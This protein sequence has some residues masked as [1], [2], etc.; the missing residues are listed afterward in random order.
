MENEICVKM[1][2][3]VRYVQYEAEEHQ[4]AL[5]SVAM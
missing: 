2:Q 1:K 5:D 4:K 3:Y